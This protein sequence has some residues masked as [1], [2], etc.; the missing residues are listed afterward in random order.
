M[1]WVNATPRKEVK[2]YRKFFIW[3]IMM[4]NIVMTTSGSLAKETSK[5]LILM[6]NGAKSEMTK[7]EE[8][9][10]EKV[11]SENIYKN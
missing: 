5:R 11:F 4:N 7:D 6:I 10:S 3:R 1:Q 2:I 9:E 8:N